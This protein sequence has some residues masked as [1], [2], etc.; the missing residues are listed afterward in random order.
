MH[1]RI[2]ASILAL[3]AAAAQAERIHY[4][5][6]DLVK[7]TDPFEL[8]L[9]EGAYETVRA[10]ILKNGSPYTGASSTSWTGILYYAATDEDAVGMVVTNTGAGA[11]YFEW[12]LEP[13]HSNTAGVYF[14]QFVFRGPSGRTEEWTRGVLT[15]QGG[16]ATGAVT[17]W[18]PN[19][20]AVYN[21]TEIDALLASM[22]TPAMRED[23]DA[24]ELEVD[25]ILASVPD[26]DAAF[27]WGDHAAEGYLTAETDPDFTA[28]AAAAITSGNIDDWNWAMQWVYYYLEVDA[29]IPTGP[30]RQR[31][32]T[33]ALALA[34]NR[35]DRIEPRTNTW[36]T[37]EG[38]PDRVTAVEAYGDR[39]TAAEAAI[40]AREDI[41]DVSLD[42]GLGGGVV[43]AVGAEPTGDPALG[44]VVI[45]AV[46]TKLSGGNPVLP[47]DSVDAPNG[48]TFD[49]FGRTMLG[50]WHLWG[51]LNLHGHA[52]LGISTDTMYF[53]DGGS[54]GSADLAAF[55]AATQDIQRVQADT[56]TWNAAAALVATALQPASTG[57]LPEAIADLN[58]YTGRVAGVEAYTGRV[59]EAEADV[60]V[61][62]TGKVG[63]V[64]FNASNAVLQAAVDAAEAEAGLWPASSNAVM[65]AVALAT[66]ALQA[67]A[68]N[69]VPERLA[70]VE[71]YTGRVAAVENYT[72]DVSQ[73]AADIAVLQT[74]KVNNATLYATNA[75]LAANIATA[76][77]T[78]AIWPAVSNAIATAAEQGADAFSWGNHAAAGYLTGQTDTF[79]RVQVA[80]ENVLG[81]N[82]TTNPTI[83]GSAAGWALAN[84]SYAANRIYCP[85]GQT[86][87]I[88]PSNALAIAAC[89]FY[90]VALYRYTSDSGETITI[91]LG[92]AVA[93]FQEGASGD[94]STLLYTASD[95]NLEIEVTPTEDSAYIDNI[96][97][98]EVTA[99]DLYAAGTI[100]AAA[101][102]V[103]G[104]NLQQYAGRIA[105]QAVQGAEARLAVLETGTVAQAAWQAS[106]AVLQAQIDIQA[107]G[108]V[109][110][111]SWQGSNA[112]LQAQIDGIGTGEVTVV[113]WQASNAVLQ[114]QLNVAATG[115]W[116]TAT[117]LSTAA[118]LQA[119]LDVQATGKVSQAE[120]QG[121]NAVLQ[122]Q[123]D[124]QSTGMV[125][126]AAWQSSNAVLQAQLDVQGTGMVAQAAWQGS[127]AVLQAQIDAA[128]T[129]HV[130]QSDWQGSN[131][132]LQAQIN[133]AAAS[134]LTRYQV[135]A[136]ADKEMYV[137]ATATGI[138]ATVVGTGITLTIPSGVCLVSARIRWPGTDGTTITLDLGTTDMANSSL[139]DRWGCN[140]AVYREDT[141]ALITTASAK[142]VTATHD[143]IQI[144]G[145]HDTQV[146]HIKLAF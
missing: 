58:S 25:G 122:A 35:I 97:V 105:T 108:K 79:D 119:Q 23:I 131:A 98:R 59:A 95:A 82:L 69:G 99:G 101:F 31:I 146:N 12:D 72:A 94:I 55:K 115:K 88:S 64:A 81:S 70:A 116:D 27:A 18:D 80:D 133:A 102:Q 104:T 127:N 86:A 26:Y 125:A 65:A 145:L 132:V 76:A 128:A 113:A 24:L 52:I 85:I 71:A 107:T 5:T 49:W 22:E 103:G 84:A 141:G 39:I 61:L 45:D 21:R 100:G 93:T 62:Q 38:I 143:Q 73:A 126:Q 42:Y 134:P 130:T 56:N 46:G 138:T 3:F 33:N 118:V 40:T 48:W 10:V 44:D 144:Q 9:T 60:A 51:D 41:F 112:V 29:G 87:S 92:G 19:Y 140:C 37:I 96:Y 91:S 36:N 34:S 63:L 139:A 121:S 50:D 47:Y 2:L 74:G 136:T 89:R 109:D 4:V 117:G 67:D 66:S 77:A 20:T 15:M 43:R 75:A 142:L 123:L 106:N 83:T 57:G 53:E 129:N 114:A 90:Q 120:W 16:G 14:A 110:N 137:L 78:A 135:Y 124:V 111:A 32:V 68:T 30:T 54:L 6:L 28:S 7:K 13:K 17:I 1:S 11:A 8:T